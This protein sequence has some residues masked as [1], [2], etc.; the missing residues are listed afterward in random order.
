[1]FWKGVGILDIIL[2]EQKNQKKT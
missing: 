1:M 2:F